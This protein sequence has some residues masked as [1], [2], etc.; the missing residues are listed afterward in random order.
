MLSHLTSSY[1]SIPSCSLLG[2]QKETGFQ[3]IEGRVVEL[4]KF[5]SVSAFVDALNKDGEDL[6]ILIVNAGVF[7]V[8]FA[9]TED[10]WE[11]R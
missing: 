5:A 6:D 7:A 2:L 11:R 1:I 10:G 3:N 9:Q 8:Q 4:S